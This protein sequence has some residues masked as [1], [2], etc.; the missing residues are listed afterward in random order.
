MEFLFVYG[1]NSFMVIY[2]TIYDLQA[3]NLIFWRG[4]DKKS[5]GV[6]EK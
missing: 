2:I 6:P 3:K 1:V 4:G 5:T